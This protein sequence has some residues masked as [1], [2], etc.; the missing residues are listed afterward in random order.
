REWLLKAARGEIDEPRALRQVQIMRGRLEA[1]DLD[2]ELAAALKEGDEKYPPE[3][4]PV[5]YVAIRVGPDP[6]ETDPATNEAIDRLLEELPDIDPQDLPDDPEDLS[7]ADSIRRN[8][9]TTEQIL[10]LPPPEW[11]IGNYLVKNSL[12]LLYGPSGCGKTFLSLDWALH[13][14]TG[15]YWHG[16]QVDGG[17]VLYIAAEGVAGIGKRAKA[18]MDHHR[19]YDLGKYHPIHWLPE[20]VN[21]AEPASVWGLIEVVEELQPALIVIDTLARSIVGADENSAKD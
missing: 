8:L 20:A 13:V 9:R 3:V 17:S 18:W 7:I 1:G 21:I 10:D 12:A 2:P 4:D 6:I 14:A 11:L 19:F 15:S 5:R 16:N